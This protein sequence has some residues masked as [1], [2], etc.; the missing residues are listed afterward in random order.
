[1]VEVFENYTELS[2]IYSYD[3]INDTWA[4]E[5]EIPFPNSIQQPITFTLGDEAYFCG[6]FIDCWQRYFC[7]K[8]NDMVL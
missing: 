4:F 7:S 2:K 1:M 3:P 5:T 6:G 8:Q